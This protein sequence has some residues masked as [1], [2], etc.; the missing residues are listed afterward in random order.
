VANGQWPV[1]LT[2]GHDHTR[3]VLGEVE[4]AKATGGMVALYPRQHDAEL[5]VVEGGESIEELHCTVIYLGEDVRDQD[6]TE[7]IEQLDYVS[8]N[9]QEIQAQAF[10]HAV[11]NPDGDEPCAVY[12]IGGTPDITGLFRELKDFVSSRY[13]GAKEQHDPFVP[14]VTA[15]Y[16]L[17]PEDLTYSGPVLFDRIGLRWPEHDQDFAL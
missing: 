7:L 13:P 17:K 10:G 3:Q 12:L 5:L 15:G 1:V 16:G 14:H 6:P 2:A 11:F 9:F 4:Q 8:Q